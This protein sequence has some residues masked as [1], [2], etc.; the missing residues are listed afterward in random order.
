M[1]NK[2]GGGGGWS[3]REDGA[4]YQLDGGFSGEG[5]DIGT[6]DFTFAPLILLQCGFDAIDDVES[7][8]GIFIRNSILLPRKRRRVV[9]QY[10]PITSLSPI[11][12][13]TILRS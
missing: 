9:Q 2:G 7:P 8:S 13:R 6:G 10:R 3:E 1:I 4:I 11:N 5:Q 12:I